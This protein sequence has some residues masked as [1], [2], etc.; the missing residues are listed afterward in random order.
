MP[1]QGSVEIVVQADD[2]RDYARVIAR[3]SLVILAVGV[4]LCWPLGLPVV[5]GLAL[6]GVFSL[7]KFRLRVQ[8]LLRFQ[9]A[10]AKISFSRA[11]LHAI[12]LYLLTG[13]ILAVCAM[14]PDV[15]LI[16]VV[17]GVFLTNVVMIGERAV[18]WLRVEESLPLDATQ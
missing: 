11:W 5:R 7:L 15:E 12:L 17:A 18:P 9:S 8:R 6:G 4:V 14:R 13:V 10:C 2:L 1:E 3:R 16:A